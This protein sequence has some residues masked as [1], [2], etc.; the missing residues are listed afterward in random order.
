MTLG[1]AGAGVPAEVLRQ[2]APLVGAVIPGNMNV[3]PHELS[4][5]QQAASMIPIPP[6]GGGLHVMLPHMTGPGAIIMVGGFRL[7]IAPSPERTMPASLGPWLV[8]DGLLE[9]LHAAAIARA[10]IAKVI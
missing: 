7:C 9:L 3:A 5:R 10:P 4:D 2:P 1:Q 8:A 6:A